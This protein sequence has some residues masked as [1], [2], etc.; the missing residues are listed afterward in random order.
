MLEIERTSQFKKDYKLA[1]KRG[2][3]LERIE[4]IINALAC[5]QPLAPRHKP[6]KLSGD[7]AGYWECHVEPDYLMMYEY[8]PGVLVLTRLGTHSDLF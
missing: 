6:H 5:G 8:A 4:S 7:L 1:K 3:K 2:K